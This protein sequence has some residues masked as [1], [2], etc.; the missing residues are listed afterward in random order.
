MEN[1]NKQQQRIMFVTDTGSII[2]KEKTDR[3]D[4]LPW[5]KRLYG[6]FNK[7][8]KDRFIDIVGFDVKENENNDKL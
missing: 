5:Y 7:S 4:K 2:G 8:Y 6:F 3:F 1:E